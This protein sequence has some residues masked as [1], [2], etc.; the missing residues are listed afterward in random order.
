M[1]IDYYDTSALLAKPE[2]IK[3]NY[4][5]NKQIQPCLILS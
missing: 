4:N 3:S 2:L 5:I 1:V